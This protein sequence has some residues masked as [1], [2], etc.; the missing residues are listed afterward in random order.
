MKI[1]ADIIESFAGAYLSPRY[2]NAQPTPDF[3]RD[4][5]DRYCG[6]DP[7]CA[8]AAPRNHAKSTALTH[9][10]ILSVALF[11]VEAYIILV[12]SSEDMAIEHLG[13]IA[14]ELRENDDLIRDFKIKEFEV[15][16]KT[17]IIVSCVDGYQFRIIARGAEQK[18]RGRKWRGKRPGLVL[19][20]DIEDDEQVENKDRRKKFRRWFFR[21]CK[22]ALRDGGK[23]R[24]HG[25][26][27]H[28]DS[29]L[30]RLMK[31]G[32]WNSVKYRAHRSFNDFT[33]IL[34]PEK[35]PEARLRAIR[36]EFINEGDSAGYSQEYLN[37]PMDHDERYVRLEYFLP[38]EDEDYS[39]PATYAAAI[40]FAVSTKDTANR[41]SISVGCKDARNILH[42]RDQ[43]VGRWD[44]QQI[45]D[46]MF[47]VAARWNPDVFFVEDGV[48]WKALAP[49][50]NLEM[51]RRDEFINI[52]AINPTQDKA[53]RARPMQKRMKAGANRYDK[54]ASWYAEFEA[55][56]LSFVAGAEAI[57]DDQF[58]SAALLNKGFDTLVDVEEDDFKPE[59]EEEFD[60]M[61]M[62]YKGGNEGRSVV[63]GY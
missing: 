50:V 21:A 56:L 42:H 48:I 28:E 5:W 22:Q 23:I 53:V 39:V 40:D 4:C 38:M 19:F 63:T 59:E 35:F 41:T 10:Y 58:D 1:T 52:Q 27:L 30:S 44:A 36:Q 9:D 62:M 26:I 12:G 45:I 32:S 16:Q 13:D 7:A 29:L 24:G 57:L 11:R 8:T 51:R 47:A 31:N 6:D 43:R 46:E 54:R 15:D 3:H 2:D 49:T 60:R 18:I 25:T 61:A 20:D 14:N 55:E 34:W 17:D 33:D 37:D